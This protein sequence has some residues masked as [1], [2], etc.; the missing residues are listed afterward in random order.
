MPAAS[1]AVPTLTPDLARDLRQDLTDA[2]FTSDHLEELLDAPTRAA[3]ERE[4]PI[5]ALRALAGRSDA[6]SVLFTV[7]ALGRSVPVDALAGALPR[8]GG[9]VEGLG[10]V[11]IT[12]GTA[13]PLFEL[14]PYTATDDAGE[15][16]WWILSDLSELATGQP[17]PPDHVLGVGGASLT[18][19]RIT[20]RDRVGRALD[21]GCG[22][23]IQALHLARHAEQVVATDLSSRALAVAAVNAALNGIDLDLREGSLLE[24]VAGE[25]FDLIVSNPPFVISPSTGAE[26][27]TYRDGGEPGDRLLARLLADLPAHLVPG[28]RAVML[29]NWEI[30]DPEHWDAHPRA[31][32]ERTGLDA[33]VL[34]R[35]VSDPAA[36]AGTWARDGGVTPRDAHWVDLIGAWLDD[37]AARRVQGVGFGWILL[38]RP[39]DAPGPGVV[40]EH[41]T[42]HGTGT[43]A[44][45]LWES[46]AQ[47]R[48]LAALDDDQLFSLHAVRA[49]EV[50]ERRHLVPGHVDPELIELVQGAGLGRIVRADQVLAATV[51]ACDG[52]LSLGQILAAVCALTGEDLDTTRERTAPQ[53]R[54]LLAWG[55]LREG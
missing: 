10:L 26:T 53:L 17:L 23:G 8:T 4:D 48:R 19:A 46:L 45:N 43:L 32:L 25:T 36:Y 55:L 33:L 11:R 5:P 9:A 39:A 28:G 27:W 6:A 1:P 22:G 12:D 40:T 21:L 3:L 47:R 31:W 2:H 20:P 14:Q 13:H 7:F 30:T 34:Q 44:P 50:R 51:G 38:Q 24:P 41:V 35:E 54:D 37:F 29:G 15:I 49:D 16:Q 42:T 18:L 52:E